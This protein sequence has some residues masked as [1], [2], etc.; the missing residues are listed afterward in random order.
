MFDLDVPVV[1]QTLPELQDAINASIRR[2]MQLPAD[3]SPVT[4]TTQTVDIDVSDGSLRV[5]H[6]DRTTLTVPEIDGEVLHEVFAAE[7]TIKGEPL[8]LV[9]PEGVSVP[10]TIRAAGTDVVFGIGR[11]LGGD[12]L[13]M[14]P[15]GGAITATVTA[16][17]AAMLALVETQ[18][19]KAAAEKG[20][21]VTDVETRLSTPT[22]QT[23]EIDGR[24]QGS[25]KV[26]FF[27]ASFEITFEAVVRVEPGDDPSRDG[28]HGRIEHLELSGEGS[29]LSM[30]LGLLKPKIDELK[31]QP[32][33]LDSLLAAAGLAGT[34]VDAV[35]VDAS[36]GQLSIY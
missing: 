9:D 3:A 29:I 8:T 18:A 11:A 14:V 27:N 20:V 6:N 30:M 35:R 21:T 19:R 24:M 2:R 31:R 15:T 13:A 25:K 36:G 33:A 32:V 23:V 16:P 22:P 34:V 10:T 4:L 5:D 26:G 28:L 12:G 1:P 7:L 17:E